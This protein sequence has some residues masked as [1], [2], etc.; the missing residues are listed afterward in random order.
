MELNAFCLPGPLSSC[1]LWARAYNNIV[2]LGRGPQGDSGPGFCWIFL[3]CHLLFSSLLFFPRTLHYYSHYYYYYYN[4]SFKLLTTVLMIRSWSIMASAWRTC[5]P[6][7]GCMHAFHS[8]SQ[9]SYRPIL[10]LVHSMLMVQK[11][12]MSLIIHRLQVDSGL[13]SMD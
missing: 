3:L 11:C 7:M 2:G 8:D 12:A 1:G 13:W 5:S 9:I 10:F 6:I 4:I